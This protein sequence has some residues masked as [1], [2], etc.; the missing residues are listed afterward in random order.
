MSTWL[1]DA[2]VVEKAWA[3]EGKVP[4]TPQSLS[5][6]EFDGVPWFSSTPA[7]PVRPT[8]DLADRPIQRT[9][10]SEHIQRLETPFPSKFIPSALL[11]DMEVF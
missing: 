9:D 10:R 5:R 3:M 1:R 11:Y 4:D 2:D 6:E 8:V 7:K